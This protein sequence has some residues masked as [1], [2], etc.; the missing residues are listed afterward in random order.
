MTCQP[1]F[2]SSPPWSLVHASPTLWHYGVI[3]NRKLRLAAFIY[4]LSH[5]LVLLHSLCCCGFNLSLVYHYIDLLLDEIFFRMMVLLFLFCLT[6]SLCHYL[7]IAT[8]LES[9]I[10]MI[11]VGVCRGREEAC[12]LVLKH[13]SSHNGNCVS[14][15]HSWWPSHLVNWM[16]DI[17]LLSCTPSISK[18]SFDAWIVVNF[19]LIFLPAQGVGSFHNSSLVWLPPPS[20]QWLCLIL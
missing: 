1:S 19:H 10:V 7:S 16:S 2:Y 12:I 11:E 4:A 14:S 8:L 18:W 9:N 13:P 3:I 6:S 5:F 17:L 20:I 15:A